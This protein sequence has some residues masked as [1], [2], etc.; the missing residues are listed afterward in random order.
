MSPA[1]SPVAYTP[2]E[3]RSYLP[4]GWGILSPDSGSWDAARQRWTVE[5]YDGADNGWTVEVA[6]GD[7]QRDGRMEALKASIDRIWRK[8]LGRK[9]VLTG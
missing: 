3:I 9:S 7:A 8:S 5:I 1:P 2:T 6:A 4:S